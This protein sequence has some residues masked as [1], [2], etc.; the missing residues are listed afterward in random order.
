MVFSME[1]IESFEHW[2]LQL[3]VMVG[4]LLLHFLHLSLLMS[5]IQ[6][7]RLGLMKASRSLF[8]LPEEVSVSFFAFP[9]NSPL[10]KVSS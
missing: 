5:P 1:H 8:H 6:V 3:A 10:I 4:L 7:A 2:L 9:L